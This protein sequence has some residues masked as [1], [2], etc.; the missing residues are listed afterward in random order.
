MG[1]QRENNGT[2]TLTD[3]LKQDQML[4]EKKCQKYQKTNIF[5]NVQLYSK[6]PSEA[7]AESYIQIIPTISSFHQYKN[8]NLKVI[9]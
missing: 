4:L 3:D 1:W 9:N 5:K 7:L 8:L 2:D 6:I